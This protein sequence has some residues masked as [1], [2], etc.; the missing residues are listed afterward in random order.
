MDNPYKILG[1]PIT[2]SQ[3]EIRIAFRILAR[4]YHPDLN[5][6]KDSTE[7]FKAIAS[8]YES[9][10]DS[11]KKKNI[12]E[13][14]SKSDRSEFFRRYEEQEAKF[15]AERKYRKERRLNEQEDKKTTTH[16]RPKK[17]EISERPSLL[18]KIIKSTLNKPLSLL[19]S[20]TALSVVEVSVTIEEA[21]FG[22]NK[23]IQ[24]TGEEVPRKVSIS[25]PPGI[26]TGSV[27]TM[28]S[29]GN[30]KESLM[31]II[32]IQPHN[33]LKIDSRGV[34]AEI[35]ITI[36][37]ALNGASIRIPTFDDPVLLKIPE[38]TQ[39]GDELRLKEKGVVY[40]DGSRGDLF[41]RFL[42][43]LPIIKTLKESSVEDIKKTLSSLDAY[44]DKSVRSHLGESLLSKS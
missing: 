19:N 24:I 42:I 44:Y 39:S 37:E 20:K 16:S 31:A 32:R 28:K 2:A 27:V 34:I 36:R 15:A 33:F 5:P 8:A 9:L 23:I 12:D 6:E 11:T 22:T 40:K 7:R 4:R 29:K 30:S 1:I 18:K 13:K 21:I 10:S 38:G 17:K 35:P 43:Q 41:V 3:D 25:I 26:R 14:L